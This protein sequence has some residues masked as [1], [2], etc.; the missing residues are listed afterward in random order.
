MQTLTT[1]PLPWR[2]Y[3]QRLPLGAETTH[4]DLLRKWGLSE[5]WRVTAADGQSWIAKRSTGSMARELDVYREVL[6]PLGVPRPELHSYW[7]TSSEQFFILE[8]VGPNTLEKQPQL[9]H[10][11]EAARVLARVRCV[12]CVQMQTTAVPE[13][14]KVSSDFYLQALDYLLQHDA[15]DASRKAVLAA[16]A[17][18][19]P[20]RLQDL[21]AHVPA[22][23]CHNDYHVK[24]LV[25]RNTIVVPIDWAMAYISPYL[26]DMYSLLH[27]ATFRK[28]RTDPLLE[29]Y[30]VE[31]QIWAARHECV[32]SLMSLP[33]NEQ[34]ALGAV[35][36]LITS[37]RWT[38]LEAIY[39]LP[40]SKK[41]IPAMIR[42]IDYYA[43][44]LQ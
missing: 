39:E 43:R 18:W 12:S 26:G 15:L 22:T 5:V 33:L 16:V 14:F 17:R 20:G 44:Q 40:E 29:A 34:L 30:T 35:C 4:W 24:N 23:L 21:Y 3:I 10:F 31:M 32:R 25:V 13:H 9:Q 36:I 19:L 6:Q 7:Q 38:L 2:E 1:I 11:Q 8:D 27:G 41:W 42:N 37:I 28:I